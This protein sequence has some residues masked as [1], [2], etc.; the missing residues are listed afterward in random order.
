[1]LSTLTAALSIPSWGMRGSK[2]LIIVRASTT[3]WNLKRC[4]LQNYSQEHY[5]GILYT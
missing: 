4:G 1:V 3:V 2:M 5:S